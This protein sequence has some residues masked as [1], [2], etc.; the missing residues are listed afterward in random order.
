MSVLRDPSKLLRQIL[1]TRLAIDV[2]HELE[3][4]HAC[5]L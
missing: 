1:G 3:A 5:V 4:Q 2:T